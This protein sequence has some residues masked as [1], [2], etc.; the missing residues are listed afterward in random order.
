MLLRK[1]NVGDAEAASRDFSG[2]TGLF[3]A[4]GLPLDARGLGLGGLTQDEK[5]FM[6][7]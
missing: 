7:R 1:S 4:L 5:T 2:L 6:S 3:D